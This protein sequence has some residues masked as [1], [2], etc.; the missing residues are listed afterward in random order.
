[1]YAGTRERTHGER[2][3]ANPAK[4][5]NPTVT[6][7]SMLTSK[8]AFVFTNNRISSHSLAVD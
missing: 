3:E 1:M 7:S 5:A 8:K 2:K 6:L 4:K